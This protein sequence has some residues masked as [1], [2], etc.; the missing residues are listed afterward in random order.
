VYGRIFFPIRDHTN[1]ASLNAAV[2]ASPVLASPP[3]PLPHL[4]RARARARQPV[5]AFVH[6]PRTGG[7]T[8]SWAISENYSHQKAPG[9]YQKDPWNTRAG[10]ESLGSR[11]G[12]WLAVGDH[13]PYGLYLRYLPANAR[14]IT[15]L[16]DPVDR[17]L[18]HYHFHA[19]KGLRKL[20]SI[21]EDLE[22]FERIEREGNESSDSIVLPE[23]TEFSLEEGLRRKIC[24]YDNFMT[25][26]LWGG[27]SLF[28]ELP[29]DALERAKQ[30]VAAFWFVG[31]RERL[32]E[33]II[34][35]G[36]KLGVGLM[37]YY[38]RHVSQGRPSLAETSQDLRELIAEHNAL[39]LELYEF[40][41][42]RFEEEA[43]APGELAQEV[44]ELRRRSAQATE[45]AEAERIAAREA[46]RARRLAEKAE[47]SAQRLAERAERSAL[48]RAERSKTNARVN[49]DG[50]RPR[51]ERKA[52]RAARNGGD[53]ATE[54]ATTSAAADTSTQRPRRAKKPRT[55]EKEKARR[56]LRTEDGGG[57]G[58]EAER[59]PTDDRTGARG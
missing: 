26:F 50:S 39:D 42:A 30:N 41:R 32:D 25:R 57:A 40:S 14:Y 8:V 19:Q 11:P 12:Y 31:I 21:W 46:G 56:R 7:G 15:V 9:N 54:E 18:S 55:K 22:N 1:L 6:I 27:E 48:R 23:D 5:L 34:L 35:L 51:A 10:L 36:Q 3:L 58:T 59:A 43:P 2:F 49:A 4:S 47:M 28:G 44:A 53:R 52:A 37:P 33:S 45:A 20:R 13:I 38:R 16:R 17:I 29:S 24:I